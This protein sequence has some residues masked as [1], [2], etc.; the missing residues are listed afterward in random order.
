MYS[1]PNLTTNTSNSQTKKNS[2]P[3]IFLLSSESYES[4][5]DLDEFVD[6]FYEKIQMIISNFKPKTI[7]MDKN[8]RDSLKR[9]IGVSKLNQISESNY[10]LY[11]SKMHN[12]SLQLS[13]KTFET[14]RILEDFLLNIDSK[15][16]IDSLNIVDS[17]ETRKLNSKHNKMNNFVENILLIENLI[18]K[19]IE[20][21]KINDVLF[22]DNEL[23]KEFVQ[24]LEKLNKFLNNE[25]RKFVLD[26][27]S[28]VFDYIKIAKLILESSE[29]NQQ[30][31][32][33]EGELTKRIRI[34]FN[35]IYKK[36]NSKLF[37]DFKYNFYSVSIYFRNHFLKIFTKFFLFLMKKVFSNIRNTKLIFFR[38]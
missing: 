4:L 16:N 34:Y 18:H 28:V 36:L 11:S 23:N 9:I 32:N 35:D 29:A 30:N 5:N 31:S 24:F 8:S 20:S 25:R 14:N 2:T 12:A 7:Y 10:S 37:F 13:R 3:S 27:C 38:I 26:S 21:I 19:Q 6:V 22:K 1:S 15:N 17:I 33:Y